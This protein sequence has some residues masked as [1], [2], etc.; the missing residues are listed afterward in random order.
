MAVLI[1]EITLKDDSPTRNLLKKTEESQ[2]KHVRER[3]RIL[4][5]AGVRNLPFL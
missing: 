4:T 1:L 5:F 2:I 3:N